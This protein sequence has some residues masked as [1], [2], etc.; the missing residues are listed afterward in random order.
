MYAPHCTKLSLADF[1]VVIGEAIMGRTAADYDPKHPF[2]PTSHL[3]ISKRAFKYGRITAK[4]CDW[5]VGLMPNP[6]NGC[7]GLEDVFVEHVYKNTDNPW[8]HITAITG[9]H[10][11]GSANAETAG[12]GGFWGAPEQQSKFNNDFYRSL[13]VNGWSPDLDNGGVSG[14]H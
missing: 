11:L 3:G 4:T 14:K 7:V 1:M 10:T 13:L 6:I 9:A 5:N 2:N 12:F 8:T